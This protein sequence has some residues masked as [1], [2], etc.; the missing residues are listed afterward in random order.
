MPEYGRTEPRIFTPPLRP[1]T[2][3]TS[4]GFSVI[5]FAEEVLE[6]KLLP[7]QRWLLIHA[8]ELVE[9]KLEDNP[10]I[11]HFRFHTVLVLVG[12]QNGKSKLTE[13]L[14]L[15]F[16]MIRCVDLVIGTAQ[17]LGISEALWGE[18]VKDVQGSDVLSGYVHKVHMANG[19]KRLIMDVGEGRVS[20]YKVEAASRKG[21]RGRTGDL[22]VL[23]ELREHQDFSA[24]SAVSNTTLAK[25]DGI[26]WCITNAGDSSSVVLEHLRDVAHHILGDPDGRFDDVDDWNLDIGADDV[27]VSSALGFFEW[28]AP[29]GADPSS[30]ETWS[31]ANPS[32]GYLIGWDKLQQAYI[33]NPPAEFLTE[34]L[35]QWVTNVGEKPFPEGAWAASSDPNSYID[36]GSPLVF[37]VDV[38]PDRKHSS[39]A[40]CGQRPDGDYHIELVASFTK[41]SMIES[42]FR[43]RIDSYGGTMTVC[44]Q[45]RGCPASALISSLSAVPGLEVVLCQGTALTASCGALFDA[46]SL[47]VDDE[48]VRDDDI[49]VYHLDQPGLDL[50]AEVAQKKT[51]GDGGWA[52]DR[53]RS[54]ED[55]SPLCAATWAYG[56]SAG[57]YDAEPLSTDKKKK[58]AA[59]KTEGRSRTML[60]V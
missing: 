35:C 11:P 53:K 23:D 58:P 12:R 24:W 15:W 56:Y 3:E 52:W 30:P 45:G 4:A 14:I 5:Q 10:Q 33:E 31:Y 13:I 26:V 36:A 37:G 18:A 6:Y 8:L 17:S 2:P 39:I 42:W 21:A 46:I 1:L 60:F 54:R 22:V 7:W 32:A 50:A 55:I 19:G 16:M 51:L 40:V 49:M 43:R 20:E 28:S 38:A 41:L 57:V 44:I 48:T 27:D 47:S 59:I 29:P 25:E 9:P 34:C